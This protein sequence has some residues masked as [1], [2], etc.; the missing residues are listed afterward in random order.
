[1]KIRIFPIVLF[2]LFSLFSCEEEIIVGVDKVDPY[3]IMNAQL[4]TDDTT[5]SIILMIGRRDATDPCSGADVRVYINDNVTVRAEE[6]EM[7]E[8]YEKSVYLFDAQ[9]HPGDRVRIEA[10]ARN[11]SAIA[12]VTAP[13][14]PIIE[15]VNYSIKDESTAENEYEKTFYVLKTTVRDLPK[16]SFYRCLIKA[17]YEIVTES[18]TMTL[19]SDTNLLDPTG[20]PLLTAGWGSDDD[21]YSLSNL[22]S[23][24][25]TY[26]IFTDDSFADGKYSLN[27]KASKS[28]VNSP[29][30]DAIDTNIDR[31][32][33]KPTA[34]IKVYSM[35]FLQYK[36]II[37]LYNLDLFGY[38]VSV[39]A[40]PVS[41]PSNVEGGL[42]FVTIE[43]CSEYRVPLPEFE[44]DER[45]Y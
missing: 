17:E 44:F 10:K 42:G 1:M 28:W 5:H 21:E 13:E 20:E 18:S 37:S 43:S 24:Q 4:H 38:E 39:I 30:F 3:I 6:V 45:Y 36:Y 31:A 2:T 33:F 9:I 32:T 34:I 8:I 25:N 15:N 16:K 23:P 27:L 22:F 41:L 26:S 7:E 11:M 29:W 14:A 12:D 40:E 35:S 19:L